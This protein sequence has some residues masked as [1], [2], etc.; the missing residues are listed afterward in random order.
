MLI[1][2]IK[3]L[4]SPL[5]VIADLLNML[6]SFLKWDSRFIENNADSM[7]MVWDSKLKKKDINK[8]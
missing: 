3:I 2:I 6:I 1:L 8:A 4:L 5:A 7:N